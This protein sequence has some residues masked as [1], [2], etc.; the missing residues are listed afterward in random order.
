MLIFHRQCPP[1]KRGFYEGKGA[2]Q[3]GVVG[4]MFAEYHLTWYLNEILFLIEMPNWQEVLSQTFHDSVWA[5]LKIFYPEN[6]SLPLIPGSCSRLASRQISQILIFYR[7]CQP[8]K[9]GFYEGKG[10]KQMGVVGAMFAEYLSY[11]MMVKWDLIPNC[12]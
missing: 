7:Q 9:R 6:F 11:N 2:K 12:W 3:M 10:A 1:H 5:S 8:H 4:A